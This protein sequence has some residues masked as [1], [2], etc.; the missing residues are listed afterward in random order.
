MIRHEI[1]KVLKDN[2]SSLIS[3]D[4][5]YIDLPYYSNIGDT[6]IWKGTEEFLK[7]VPHQCL[8]RS[9]FQ[10]FSYPELSDTTVIIMHGGGN[11]G[12][13]YEPHNEL[14][15]IVVCRYPNNRI[16]IL[17]QTVY[18]EGARN[19]RE[20]ARVFRQHKRLTICARDRY[21]Y[22][23]LKAFGFGHDIRLV[24]DMA[25]CIDVN[26]LQQYSKPLL[27][28]DLLFKRVDKER[29]FVNQFE[30]LSGN[31]DVSDWPYYLDSE[32][33]VEHLYD[34]I[35]NGK[36]EEADNYAVGTYLPTRVKTGVELIS[37]Y[38]K[39]YSN[40]LHG[41]IL[42]I[43]LGKDVY[44]LDNSYGKNSQY[45]KTWL[46]GYKNVHL[47]SSS[48]KYNFDRMRRFVFHWLLS[49]ADR[50]IGK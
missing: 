15:R 34:L 13:L 4:Y 24:P 12:D 9:S 7:K 23:F 35:R 1:K 40:R 33:Q 47:L 14:R 37:Q 32:P 20:D 45:Y 8:F 49:I 25:F 50:V 22:H 48:K 30:G 21:S 43:L 2:I 36:Y 3:S 31:F 44:I 28:K 10:T 19:A 39:V 46:K 17:P 18:Y 38:D 29:S 16:I 6:L 5:I 26:E 11:W 42:S 41:A 27:H